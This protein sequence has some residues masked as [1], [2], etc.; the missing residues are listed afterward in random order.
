[1]KVE[2]TLRYL[3]RS[4]IEV[5]STEEIPEGYTVGELAQ[6]VIKAQE[7]KEEIEFAGA[8]IVT[9]IN[10][11]VATHDTPLKE[12]DEVKIMPVASAG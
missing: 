11:R 10:G 5:K 8:S 4:L 1:M 9:L 6:I 3:H 12:G 2:V 7:E